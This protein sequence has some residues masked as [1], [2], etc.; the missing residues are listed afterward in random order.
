MALAGAILSIIPLLGLIFSIIGLVRSKALG[1][2]GKTAATIGI[3]L[4]IVFAGGYGFAAYKLGNST[5]ADPACISSES[6][7]SSMES[8]LNA[9]ETALTT[10]ENSSDSSAVKTALDTMISDM[11]TIKGQLDSDVA[12][13][14]HADVKAKLQAFDT[15]LGKL[16]T[17]LK[18]VENGDTSAAT[19]LESVANRLGPEGDAVDSLCGNATNG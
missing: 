9:D 18:A 5:A 2:A 1:G 3:V 7:A 10:A 12:E 4:S 14:T 13:A 8:K 17:D 16:V 19:D 11:Q 15:D 6:A